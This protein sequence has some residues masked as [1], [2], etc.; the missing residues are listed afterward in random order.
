MT[1]KSSNN[2]HV[3]LIGKMAVVGVSLLLVVVSLLSLTQWR[4]GA[5]GF[6]QR[7][8]PA[9]G[10]TPSLQG[11]AAIAQLKERGLYDSLRAALSAAR[12]RRGDYSVGAPSLVNEQKLSA[13]DGA[14]VDQFGASVA[15]S[16]AT[17]VVGALF[18]DIGG[19]GNQG[20]AY[21]F[22]P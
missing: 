3:K 1:L 21:V 22:E 9:T 10:S 2:R 13:S 19:N 7:P 5:A 18:D 4:A 14:A 17:I 15:V 6:N 12:S 11:A 8:A 16:G 20:S